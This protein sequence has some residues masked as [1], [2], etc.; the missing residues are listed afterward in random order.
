MPE[1]TCKTCSLLKENIRFSVHNTK[2]EEL[3]YTTSFLLL[4]V[5]NSK[6]T[7][8]SFAMISPNRR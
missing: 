7:L 6:Q 8:L 1:P 2:E 4:G 5:S 3:A